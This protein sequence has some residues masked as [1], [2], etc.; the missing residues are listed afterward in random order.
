M[1]RPRPKPKLGKTRAAAMILTGVLLLGVQTGL[2][3]IPVPAFA[4]SRDVIRELD[5][6]MLQ[7]FVTPPPTPDAADGL[8]EAAPE[9]VPAEP[10]ETRT[11]E[12]EVGSAM[13]ELER[14]FAEEDVAPLDVDRVAD[15]TA[16]ASGIED[17]VDDLSDDRFESLFGVADEVVAGRG[18]APTGGDG[19]GLGIGINERPVDSGSASGAGGGLPGTAT[20]AAT[21]RTG[22]ERSPTSRSEEPVIDDLAPASF[23]GSEAQRLGE[24]MRANRT[25]LP[26]GVRVHVNFQPS[27]LTASAP[28]ASD[29]AEWE[30]FLMF[31]EALEELH[32]VLV[33]GD[34]SV[35]LID[36]GFQEQSRTFREGTVRRAEGT[37]V[38][39]DSRTGA[40]SSERAQQ[41]YDLFLAWWES[42]KND[43]G[44]L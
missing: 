11:F 13:E 5:P 39:V 23:D 43:A 4:S 19:A 17:V 6:L 41:F 10:T 29:G 42:V 44:R 38:A 3:G 20:A 28:F 16:S 35:Y 30:I 18:R 32:I 15:P 9:E 40:A 27:F 25:D 14:L 37:I 12:Q 33:Q 24:W 31:N 1:I 36:R 8:D 34:Q 7:R 2:R 26:I 22:V 21:A